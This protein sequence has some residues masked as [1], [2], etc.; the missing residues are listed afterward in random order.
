M[1]FFSTAT[2]ST[3]VVYI[4]IRH[5]PLNGAAWR[6]YEEAMHAH[7]ARHDKF[8]FCFDIRDLAGVTPEMIAN[9]VELMLG[10]KPKTQKQVLGTAIVLN[11][12]GAKTTIEGLLALYGQTRPLRLFAEDQKAVEWLTEMIVQEWGAGEEGEEGE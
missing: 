10:L 9:K 4:T 8:L 3:H 12:D 6:Q 7:Y 11:D 5:P 2:L 1:S